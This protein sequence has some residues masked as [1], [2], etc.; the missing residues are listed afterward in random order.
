MKRILTIAFALSLV[1]TGAFAQTYDYGWSLSGSMTDPGVNTGP[2]AGGLVPVYLWLTCTGSFGGW[3]AMEADLEIPAGWSNFGFT[4]MNGVL[5]AGNPTNLLLA[6][7]GCPVEPFLAGSWNLFDPAASGGGVCLVAS[8]A[9]GYN[10]T[11]DCDPLNATIHENALTGYFAG[12]GTPCE[13][14]GGDCTVSVEDASW[15]SIKGLYR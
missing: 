1:A 2:A 5:N 13:I 10:V 12:T 14:N 11:V 8:A 6:V 3:A 15:G 4:P 9:N 7:G